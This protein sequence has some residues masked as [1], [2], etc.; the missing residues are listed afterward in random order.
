RYD[1]ARAAHQRTGVLCRLRHLLYH[2]APARPWPRRRQTASGRRTRSTEPAPRSSAAGG[3]ISV[4]TSLV[5]A[6]RRSAAHLRDVLLADLRRVDLLRGR[7]ELVDRVIEVERAFLLEAQEVHA[8]DDVVLEI[9][10]HEAARFELVDDLHDL[11]VEREQ[12]L[13]ARLAKLQ[14]LAERHV[15]ERLE[16]LHDRGVRAGGEPRALLVRRTEGDE[17]GFL[18]DGGEVALRVAATRAHEAAVHADHLERAL[19]QVV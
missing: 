9:R 15:L 17:V 2:R 12:A 6:R 5:I 18:E 14:P 4:P 7:L 11:V 8:R 19:L 13:G 3:R 16:A 1:P 10:A